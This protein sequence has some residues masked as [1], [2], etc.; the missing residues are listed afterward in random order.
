MGT[1]CIKIC[2]IRFLKDG[3]SSITSD[4]YEEILKPNKSYTNHVIQIVLCKTA[5]I[6]LGKDLYGR[7]YKRERYVK[8]LC[9]NWTHEIN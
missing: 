7:I 1:F 2:L 4:L 6:Q 5:I 9:I 3:M 8:A